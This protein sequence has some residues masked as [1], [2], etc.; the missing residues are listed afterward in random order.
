MPVDEKLRATLAERREAIASSASPKKTAERHAKGLLTA[1]ERLTGLL[2]EETFQEFGAHIRHSCT[3]F[4]MADRDIPEDGV[5]VGTGHVDGRQVAAFSQDFLV[6]AGT[7][8]KMHARKIVWAQTTPP[9]NGTPLIGFKDFRR[10]PHPG[11]RRRALRLRRRLL[12]QRAAIR[13]RPAD[14]HHRRPVRRR[15]R[16]FAGADGLI[17]MTRHAQ[18]FITGP[19]VIKAVTGETSRMEDVGGAAITAAVTGNVHF[20]ADDDQRRH[21]SPRGR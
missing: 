8:G 7:L 20:I 6:V 13:R 14:R 15:R 12:P 9:D 17:I 16:L 10:R 2:Q 4:G 18:M 11:G 19:Q 21:R 3:A 1:R 5:I